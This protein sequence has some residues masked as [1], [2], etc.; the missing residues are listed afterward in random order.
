[1]EERPLWRVIRGPIVVQS[2]PGSDSQKLDVDLP[3]GTLVEQIMPDVLVPVRDGATEV[4]LPRMKIMKEQA[5][6]DTAVAEKPT[7]QK[8]A[9]KPTTQ[10]SP[11]EKDS[12]EKPGFFASLFGISGKKEEG[13]E[14]AGGSENAE[15]AE[16]QSEGWVT[17]LETHF[18][19]V[20]KASPPSLLEL[21][22]L[23][24]TLKSGVQPIRGPKG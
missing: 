18:E 6:P 5:S 24:R 2:T 16:K 22:E 23:T 11:D 15:F 13:L 21:L 8:A 10:A 4:R 20:G 3:I 1:M 14:A 12:A 19:L 9:E 17:R 7:T